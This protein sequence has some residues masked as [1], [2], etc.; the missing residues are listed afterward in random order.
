MT[1][2]VLALG[3]VLFLVTGCCDN[4]HCHGGKLV[5]EHAHKG[6]PSV[7]S[8]PYK[9]TYALYGWRKP[10]D[11]SHPEKWIADHEVDQL[12]VRGL[13]RADKVGFE[14]D[15]SGQLFAVA[16][17]EK[18]PL[19]AGRYCWHVTQ[20]TEYRGLERVLHEAGENLLTVAMLPLTVPAFIVV[21][22]TTL[23]V[24][25]GASLIMLCSV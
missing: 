1:R 11:G 24:A 5:C 13:E 16:G 7:D 21:G 25:G 23:V 6:K 4:H 10:P 22:A 12:Y 17:E 15:S 2:S 9:A 18:I 14:R 3:L 8:A 19:P 20:E